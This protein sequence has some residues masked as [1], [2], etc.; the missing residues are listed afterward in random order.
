M[1]LKIPLS[2]VAITLALLVCSGC[3]APERVPSTYHG[4]PYLGKT[5]EIPGTLS[6]IRYDEGGEGIA[7]HDRDR[8]NLAAVCCGSTFRV[9]EGVDVGIIADHHKSL[10]APL[11]PRQN[12]V[13]W[14]FEGEWIRYTVRVKQGGMYQVNAHMSSANTNCQIR[15]LAN[16]RDISGPVSVPRPTKDVHLWDVY[17]NLTRLKLKA[18]VQVLTLKF[19]KGQNGDQNYDCFEFVPA[20]R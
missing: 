20:P 16:D 7:Y 2:V 11:D 3:V 8:T 4:Q 19:S 13:G 14:I 10:G 12:Y 6:C 1:L 18:G 15:L 17:T 5:K 9:N